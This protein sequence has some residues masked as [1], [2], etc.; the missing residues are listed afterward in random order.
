MSD[1]HETNDQGHTTAAVQLP[2]AS[3]DFKALNDALAAGQAPDAAR[4]AAVIPETL[5]LS[6]DE[7]Q[8]AAAE[9]VAAAPVLTSL[10]KP[11]LVDVATAES[12]L[13][14]KDASGN[15]IAFADGTRAQMIEAIE[16]RRAGIDIFAPADVDPA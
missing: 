8:A 9:S 12:V 13:E 6:A 4:E 1:T 16:G 10:S 14:A 5:A 7:A 15:R 11:D 2:P 3:V